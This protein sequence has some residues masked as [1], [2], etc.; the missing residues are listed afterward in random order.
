MPPLL[1]SRRFATTVWSREK[2]RAALKMVVR[3]SYDEDRE[4]RRAPA[5]DAALYLGGEHA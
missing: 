5:Y 3:L 1:A 2:K 4:R